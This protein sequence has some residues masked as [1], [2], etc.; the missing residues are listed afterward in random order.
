MKKPGIILLLIASALAG[1]VCGIPIGREMAGP[2]IAVSTF[3]ILPTV[4]V[5][6]LED[7]RVNL[8]TASLQELDSLPGI[9]PVLAQ[10][11]LDYRTENGPFHSVLD[12]MGVEGIGPER[13][14]AMLEFITVGGSYEDTGN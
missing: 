14:E 9:G 13:L 1:L 8:N 11:I 4:S 6:G 10:R 3:S 2:Q 5:Q 7:A 12:L